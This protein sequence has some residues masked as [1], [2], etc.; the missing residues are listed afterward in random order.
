MKYKY[1]IISIILLLVFIIGGISVYSLLDTSEYDLTGVDGEKADA[2]EV[3]SSLK[4]ATEN[5]R[6]DTD[7]I[8]ATVNGD[9]ITAYELNLRRINRAFSDLKSDFDDSDLL[10]ELI[11]ARVIAQK[12]KENGYVYEVDEKVYDEPMQKIDEFYMSESGLSK[13]TYLHAGFMA[14]WMLKTESAFDSA[15]M[16]EVTEKSI[17]LSSVDIEEYYKNLD[18]SIGDTE[19]YTALIFELKGLYVDELIALAEIEYFE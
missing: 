14:D 10:Q 5:F 8:V 16:K 4:A 2:D 11:R 19:K 6:E 12:V 9:S 7:C 3:C 13:E 1:L 17:E 15:F 18:E